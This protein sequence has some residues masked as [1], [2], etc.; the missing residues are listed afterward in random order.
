MTP[1]VALHAG[2]ALSAVVLGPVALWARL[3]ATQR[4]RWHRAAGYAWV[5]MML[6]A[7]FSA[8]FIRYSRLAVWAGFSA[9]HL[10]IPATLLMLGYAF[11]ALRRGNIQGHQR[12]M[13]GLYLGACVVTGAFTLRPNRALGQIVWGDWLG[14]I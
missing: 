10:L 11:A 1:L 13:L 4:P 9:I 2:F 6:G 14:W 8:L 5:S 7:A 12:M 3:G